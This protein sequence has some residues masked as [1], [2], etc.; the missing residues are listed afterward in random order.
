MGAGPSIAALEGG[1][2]D[3]IYLSGSSCR[4]VPL[5]AHFFSAD[6]TTAAGG[7]VISKA[8]MAAGRMY[9]DAR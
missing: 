4:S 3:A 2:G 6:T 1:Q 9:I 5:V 7:R 8:Q